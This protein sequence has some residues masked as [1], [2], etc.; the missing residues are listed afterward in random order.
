MGYLIPRSYKE[1]LEFDKET[2]PNGLMQ[3]GMKWIVSRNKKSS[4][5]VKGPNGMPTIR[6]YSMHPQPPKDQSNLDFLCEVQRQAQ[7]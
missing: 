7:N 1:A 6:G 4:P 3:Q 2:T 5:S